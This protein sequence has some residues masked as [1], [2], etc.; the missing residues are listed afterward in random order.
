MTAFLCNYFLLRIGWGSFFFLQ[1]SVGMGL[2]S[3]PVSTDLYSAG[4]MAIE[5]STELRAWLQ[6][7]SQLLRSWAGS[8][9]KESWIVLSAERG[10]HPW[11]QWGQRLLNASVFWDSC[12]SIS[13][14]AVVNWPLCTAHVVTAVG[15]RKGCITFSPFVDVQCPSKAQELASRSHRVC[16]L[17]R[18]FEGEAQI[19]DQ[20][21]S[22]PKAVKII[23]WFQ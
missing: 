12:S 14:W 15:E 3:E 16:H 11:S 13:F 9:K 21:L 5:L 2:T 4:R 10:Q 18:S 17:T 7:Q 1:P 19:L 6:Q 23:V 20:I 22:P 8:P